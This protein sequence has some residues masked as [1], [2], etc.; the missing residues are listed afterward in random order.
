[1][2]QTYAFPPS[3]CCLVSW[4][5]SGMYGGWSSPWRFPFVF[6]PWFPGLLGLLVAV[7]VFLP[8]QRDLLRLPLSSFLSS[9]RSPCFASLCSFLEHFGHSFGFSLLGLACLPAAVAPPPG[10]PTTPFCLSIV[11]GVSAIAILFHFRPCRVA[12]FSF[13]FELFSCSFPFF[14]CFV[15]LRVPWGLPLRTSCDHFSLCS[16][17]FFLLQASCIFILYCSVGSLYGPCCLRGPPCNP[18]SP[19]SLWGLPWESLFFLVSL[20]M[21]CWFRVL[22]A[23]SEA[24]FFF[25]FLF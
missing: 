2:L 24:F 14:S 7:L 3:V 18:L 4:L 19:C 22:C 10:C 15:W 17:F 12:F 6:A 1:M 23:V 20:A 16:L 9:S 25:F 11:L 5:S 21:A 13:V 8:Q